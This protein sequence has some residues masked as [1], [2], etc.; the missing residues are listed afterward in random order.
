MT[1]LYTSGTISLVNGSAVITGIDTAW[2]T[3]LIVG[4]TVHVEAEGNPLPILADDSAGASEHPITDTQMTAAIKWQG[5]S[6]TYKYALV[7]ENTYTTAQAENST[8]IA[9]L[10]RRLNHPTIAAIAAVQAE[11]DHLIL[12][13]GQST[14]TIIPRSSLIQGIKTN[15]AAETPEGLATYE[16]EAAGFIVLV[17]DAGDERAALYFKLSAT[18]GDWSDPAFLTGEKGIK[19]DTGATG[20]TWRGA[21]NNV[22]AYAKNDVVQNNK[23]AWIALRGNT[24]VAPPGLPTT[25]NADW[26]LF[27]RA[28]VDGN[29]TGDVVGPDGGVAAKQIA[30]FKTATGKDIEGLTPAE[31]RSFAA[32]PISNFRNKIMNPLGALNTRGVGSPVTL[33]AGAFGH[34]RMKA[35]A[36]G[37]TYTP[38]TVNG[39]TTF[40]ISAGSLQQTMEARG[41]AG[42]TGRYW[43]SWLGTAQARINGGAYGASETVFVDVDATANVTV[44]F[45]VGSFS[46]PQF[47]LGYVSSFS[48]RPHVVEEML[49]RRFLPGIKSDGAGTIPTFGFAINASNAVFTVPFPVKAR[50]KPTGLVVAGAAS[51]TTFASDQVVTGWTFGGQTSEVAGEVSISTSGSG[52]TPSHAGWLRASGGALNIYFTGADL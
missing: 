48:G 32:V 4:G 17:A 27:A 3:A 33:A 28:G 8:K 12:L 42:Q 14:A 7:R 41:F 40:D 22:A 37:C 36:S 43:L 11:Q 5:A 49:C 50:V 2:K 44:E 38:I 20:I 31:V 29:G 45:G 25:A 30:G 9:E 26:E 51:F 47:E 35:G 16:S 18:A 34:D 24:G 1:A 46:L 13:T 15:G 23:S 52:Y 39:V 19:G 6:G 21:W 10:L